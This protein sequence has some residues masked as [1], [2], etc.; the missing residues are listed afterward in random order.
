MHDFRLSDLLSQDGERS[1]DQAKQLVRKH[2]ESVIDD[3][4]QIQAFFKR[5]FKD[6]KYPNLV[7]Y[8]ID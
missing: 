4:Q 8:A 7:V 2:L 3:K 1:L 6:N 5:F